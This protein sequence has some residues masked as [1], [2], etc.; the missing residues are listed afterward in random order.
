MSK[1]EDRAHAGHYGKHP[2]Q[3][4]WLEYVKAFIAV[5]AGRIGVRYGGI[6]GFG[7]SS[8]GRRAGE[9]GRLEIVWVRGTG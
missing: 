7:D 9:G 5:E 3:G 4:D 8:D 2:T 1:V 6:D